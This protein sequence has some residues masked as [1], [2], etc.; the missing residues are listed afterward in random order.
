MTNC[1]R[2][3]RSGAR[4]VLALAVLALALAALVAPPAALASGAPDAPDAQGEVRLQAPEEGSGDP[5]ANL[6]F[7]FA[8]FIITWALFFAYVG[9]MTLKR[10]AMEREI[11]AL[12]A[13]I[14]ERDA[15][16]SPGPE[17]GGDGQT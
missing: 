10:R 11:E 14:A 16:P 2:R 9:Y 8:V 13:S 3:R 7:L 17:A 5:E 6:P 12:R 4:A 15:A 1:T